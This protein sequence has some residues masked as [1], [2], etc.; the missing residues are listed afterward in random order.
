MGREDRSTIGNNR[1]GKAM[2]APDVVSKQLGCYEG[3]FL[4][5]AR[6]KY[7]LFRESVN[8]H[9]DIVITEWFWHLGKIY[10]NILPGTLGCWQW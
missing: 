4:F 2:L 7:C 3:I 1:R 8:D 10:S 9:Q 5:G 6:Y